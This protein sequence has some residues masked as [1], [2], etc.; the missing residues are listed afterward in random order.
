MLRTR[1]SAKEAL[2]FGVVVADIAETE[3]VDEIGHPGC[4]E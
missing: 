2:D 1:S 4:S 3:K